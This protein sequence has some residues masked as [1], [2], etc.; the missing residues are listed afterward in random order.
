MKV[1]QP[2]VGFYHIQING[3]HGKEFWKEICNLMPVISHGDLSVYFHMNS[4][5]LK[6]L[7]WKETFSS[8]ES[9]QKHSPESPTPMLKLPTICIICALFHILQMPSGFKSQQDLR[10]SDLH[11]P[12]LLESPALHLESTVCCVATTVNHNQ[13]W[14]TLKYKPTHTSDRHKL[15]TRAKGCNQR[16]CGEKTTAAKRF[17]VK[18]KTKNKC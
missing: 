4:T 8:P 17:T 9:N 3:D 15:C 13:Q 5:R 16:F 1:S 18:N 6:S 12:P 7:T 10:N 14:P 2:S 11:H